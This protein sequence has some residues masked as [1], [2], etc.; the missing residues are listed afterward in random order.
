MRGDQGN[1]MHGPRLRSVAIYTH[2]CADHTAHAGHF[3]VLRIF[4]PP[5]AII[6]G[7]L[8]TSQIYCRPV[9]HSVFWSQTHRT[10]FY[11]QGRWAI[12]HLIYLISPFTPDSSPKRSMHA[13]DLGHREM[14]EMKS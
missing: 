8:D 4:K 10:T 2:I 9:R 1:D 5:L 13:K 12:A 14:S 6:H 7:H 3:T 11:M